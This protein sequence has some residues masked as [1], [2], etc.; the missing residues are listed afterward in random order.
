MVDVV[1]EIRS[2]R[3]S[4]EKNEL[5]SV[6]LGGSAYCDRTV[7]LIT[8]ALMAGNL[9]TVLELSPPSN[10]AVTEAYEKVVE[11]I[12]EKMKENSTC[13]LLLHSVTD[14]L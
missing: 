3:S 13:N 7:L 2:C 9:R 11:Y 8:L 1:Q 12:R 10:A 4:T 5:G 6:F 14:G